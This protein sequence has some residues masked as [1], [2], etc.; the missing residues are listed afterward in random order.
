MNAR[1]A[2][3]GQSVTR[4]EDARFLTGNGQYTDDIA[5]PQQSYGVFLRSPHAHATIKSLNVA[6]AEKAPGVLAIFIMGLFWKKSTANAALVSALLSIPISWLMK[7][8]LPGLP[9]IDRMGVAFLISVGLIVIISYIEGK[10]KNDERGIRISKDM[11]VKDPVF[12]GLS[13]G[14]LGITAALYT[15]FW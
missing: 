15:I 1:Q 3:I 12:A 4:R 6:A 14:I 5:L 9:F 8:G 11:L 2:F 13:F 10:G 7:V